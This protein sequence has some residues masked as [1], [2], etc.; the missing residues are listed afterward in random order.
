MIVD[1]WWIV[2]FFLGAASLDMFFGGV[3]GIILL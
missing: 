1:C 3:L 2:Y